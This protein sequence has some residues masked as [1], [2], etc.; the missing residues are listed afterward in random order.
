[1]SDLSPAIS[2]IVPCY[3]QAQYL[4]ETLQ[5]VLE[6]A[7]ANWE[8]IIV[9]DGS[10][11]NTEEVAL[12]WCGKDDR[13]KYLK[14]ENGGL[15]DA[16]NYGIKHSLG[17]YILPLD[18]DDKISKD[19]TREAIEVLE[20]D[21]AIKLVFCRAQLFGGD[22]QEWEL[23]PYTYENLLF[24]RNCIYCSAIY[25][26]EDYNKTVGYN[27]NMI[28]GWEDYDFWISLLN[29]DDKVVK[30]D[31]IHFFYRTKDVSMRT[32]ITKEKEDYLRL[33]IFKNHQELYLQY[34]NPIAQ[35]RELKEFKLI[36]NS[37]QYRIG[38]YVLAPF[39]YI[40]KIFKK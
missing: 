38:G 34:I 22:N 20:K 35:F 37:L 10:P 29:K 18:S 5:T 13:F 4:P 23:L 16:R 30:L 8:C 2:I 28:Y 11:D 33:Q 27:V 25:K 19:Y 40:S 1:M 12:E 17:K 26:R 39:R 14:K 7:Y 31:K 3:N 6:Q 36:E 32:L 9:N 21:S 15:S 24:V